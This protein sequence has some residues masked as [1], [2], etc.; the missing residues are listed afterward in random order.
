[1]GDDLGLPPVTLDN[2]L[3]GL[4]VL[5]GGVV[6]SYLVRVLVRLFLRWRDASPSS[7]RVRPR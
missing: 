1:M 7:C 6:A 5:V 3:L 4:A 2:V